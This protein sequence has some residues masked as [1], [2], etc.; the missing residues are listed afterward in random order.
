MGRA[1]KH[2]NREEDAKGVYPSTLLRVDVQASP[3]KATRRF[4]PGPMER[5]A[6]TPRQG[7]SATPASPLS[8]CAPAPDIEVNPFWS[9]GPQAQEGEM[10]YGGGGEDQAFADDVSKAWEPSSTAITEA[11]LATYADA[12]DCF[13]A[14]YCKLEDP[15]YAVQGWNI[16]KEVSTVRVCHGAPT[17]LNQLLTTCIHRSTGTTS[18]ISGRQPAMSALVV[19]ALLGPRTLFAWIS[20]SFR[21]IRWRA[22]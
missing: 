16:Q 1:K 21:S 20:N 2:R 8:P 9:G 7:P 15:L 22:S 13:S 10:Q 14:G 19:L 4:K 12:V 11:Q 18:S 17:C 6:P 3:T 5:R